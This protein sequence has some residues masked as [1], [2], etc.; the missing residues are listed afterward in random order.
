MTK[1]SLHRLLQTRLEMLADK[2][3]NQYD[4][5][6]QGFLQMTQ[7]VPVLSIW[8]DELSADFEDELAD[9]DDSPR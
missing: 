6:D 7:P 8:D 1:E 5:S 2:L 4:F 3:V 9:Y